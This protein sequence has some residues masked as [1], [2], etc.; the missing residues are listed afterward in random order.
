MAE[1]DGS[2]LAVDRWVFPAGLPDQDP[3]LRVIRGQ[4]SPFTETKEEK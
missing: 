2:P 3:V 1:G 4:S